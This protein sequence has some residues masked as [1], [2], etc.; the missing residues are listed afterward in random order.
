VYRVED[1]GFRYHLQ[2][3]N[4][5]HTVVYGLQST[6][7]STVFALAK[8]LESRCSRVYALGRITEL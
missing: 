7:H 5:G 3:G 4:K 2:K 6:S 1:L 8:I